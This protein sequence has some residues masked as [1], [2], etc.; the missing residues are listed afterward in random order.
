MN[1]WRRWLACLLLPIAAGLAAPSPIAA[2]PLDLQDLGA[3][4]FTTFTARDGLPEAVVTQVA[5]GRLGYVWA[6]T[7]NGVYR[8]DGHR[9]SGPTDPAMAHEVNALWVDHD[10]TLW[11]GLR[12]NG[13]ARWD[14]A[15]WHVQ[16]RA[17]G[18]P[19]QQ[20]RNF[21]ETTDATGHHT[22]WALTW[23]HGLMFYRDGHWQPDPGNASLPRIPL[24]AM[25]QTTTLGGSRR[26]WIGSDD[27][28]WFRDDGTTDW[29][30]WRESELAAAPINQLLTTQ[31]PSGEHLW[32]AAYSV[33]LLRLDA[34]G[35][36][37]WRLHEGM[38]SEEIFA[39]AHSRAA[40]GEQT[41]WAGTR[42]GL[43]RLHG[44]N[45]Q[46]FDRRHGLPSDAI[47]GLNVWRSP[48]GT[49]VLWIATEGG[50]ARVLPSGSAWTTASLLG[51][52]SNGVFATV[53]QTDSAGNER[54]WAGT[55]DAGLGLYEHGRWRTFSQAD[56]S[57]PAVGLRSLKPAADGLG[58]WVGLVGGELAR[59][60][61][62]A[63]G[64]RFQ[65][66]PTPWPKQSQSAVQVVLERRFEGHDE[67]WVGTRL[68][69]IHVRRDGVW[70]A[71]QLPAAGVMWRVFGLLD[72]IDSS[73]H[74]WLWASSNRG[75]VRFDG[76]RWVLFG[77]ADGFP[78]WDLLGINRIDDSQGR[79]I[80][81][82]GTGD[83]GIMRV[84]VS[85]PAHPRP[86]PADLPAPP[87]STVYGALRDSRGRIY[88]CSNNG[89]QQLTPVG[90]AYRSR[91]FTRADGMLHDEC[92]VNAQ[93][94]DA[95][96]RYW[97]GMLDGLTVY[98]PHAQAIDTEV[99]PLRVTG[100]LIDG[101][102]TNADRI[103]VP[104]GARE[105]RVSYGLLSW[106]RE[107]DSRFR[108]Q[109]IGYDPAP[110]EWD[111]STSRTFN[112]LPPGD[113]TLRIEGRDYAG[114]L[115]TPIDLTLAVDAHWW[116]ERWAW[117]GAGVL[118][119]LLGYGVAMGRTRRL[120]A[121]RAELER[122]VAER[123][124]QLNAAN[125]RLLALSN[126]DAL[127]G[128]A[129]RRRLLERLDE[130]PPTTG[131]EPTALI[132]IDVDH[133]KGFNDTWGHPAGDEALR[134][135]AAALGQCTPDSAVVARY[136]GEEFACLLHAT[137][138]TAA[139]QIAECYRQSVAASDI[140]I[141]GTGEIRRVT[142]SAGVASMEIRTA[143]DTRRLLRDA[144]MA[145]YKAKGD[146]RNC[147]RI[148][149]AA[150]AQAQAPDASA[151][152][153]RRPPA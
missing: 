80:L 28:L 105:T 43:V 147:V 89:V 65:I 72:Q 104:A 62:G 76:K 146:G 25:A 53:L 150:T 100:V 54:L 34:S 142:I 2:Q 99:K 126:T 30:P 145:L 41:I 39:I 124:V 69:G 68:D 95:H 6:A 19:S 82:I 48:G 97:V 133:F 106:N 50:V 23:D 93:F 74:H 52:R 63:S 114:N 120:R 86:L 58:L 98:D 153:A 143:D 66:V 137:D 31:D 79:P 111:A 136:G 29:K 70:E 15:H 73:G 91:V 33:G 46:V 32:V 10:G 122:H 115:S 71:V 17:D 9:W 139:A 117:A 149:D 92:N 75:L 49:E 78:S 64:P 135:V 103:V 148:W 140:A 60:T 129:N 118:L 83:D 35:V 90:E 4:A 125:A 7:P 14:G 18:L 94:I 121:H 108:T 37:S 130:C 110:G 131:T 152:G 56:G 40:N 119:L 59:E 96:D 61:D 42:A 116:Q 1:F 138:C 81:W 55:V 5:T 127:T 67:L 113:Y 84:D 45:L 26:Q 112:A 44:D 47:R 21:F 134:V 101:R 109:L 22:L 3:P 151:P 107:S 36:K 16:T 123:T 13:L 141:P 57:L 27:G 132:F 8:Y 87:N 144:D 38:P 20:I 85:D 88:L 24:G 102:D 12:S 77:R 128:L 11:A 51:D